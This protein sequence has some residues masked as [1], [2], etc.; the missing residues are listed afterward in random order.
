[1]GPSGQEITT[2]KYGRVKV[3][4][5][6]DREG[7]KDVD[8]SCWVRVATLWAGQQWGT[9]HIPRVGQEV[10]VAFEEGDPDMPIIVGSVYNATNMPPYTLPD[11]KTQSGILTRSSLQGDNTTFNQ[12][13]F[14]DKKGSEDI[15]FH[16]EKDFT[17]IVE[18]N[19]VLQVGYQT[20][21][22]S[23][24]GADGSKPSRSTRTAPRRSTPATKP[25]PSPRAAAP[26]ASRRTNR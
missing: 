5:Y 12:L 1:M 11:N 23:H 6:W 8:S 25:S 21:D 10:I 20:K 4:F 13:R 15:Y 3:Q 24:Q 26:T 14:E 22:G 2:D 9:I 19:D 7:K 17:R 18:N 16:A